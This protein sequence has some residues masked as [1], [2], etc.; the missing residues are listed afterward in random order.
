MHHELHAY[1]GSDLIQS[2]KAIRKAYLVSVP[3]YYGMELPFT[4]ATVR[5][6]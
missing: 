2:N 1:L 5:F 4:A 3:T 6:K